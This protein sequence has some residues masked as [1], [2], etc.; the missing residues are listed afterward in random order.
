MDVVFQQ[1]HAFPILAPVC[2]GEDYPA[3]GYSSTQLLLQDESHP[4]PFPSLNGGLGGLHRSDFGQPNATFSTADSVSLHAPT[5]L[6]GRCSG[7]LWCQ[8][9]D[10]DVPKS[11]PPSSPSS[12]SFSCHNYNPSA[13]D[14]HGEPPNQVRRSDGIVTNTFPT[15]SELLSELNSTAANDAATPKSDYSGN[16]VQQ[17]FQRHPPRLPTNH[18]FTLPVQDPISSHEKK[19]QLLECLEQYVLYLHE[20]LSLLGAQPASLERVSTY[21]GLSSRSVRTLLVH[22]ENTNKKLNLKIM[23][24]EERFLR[25]LGLRDTYLRQDL[26]ALA[27]P[28]NGSSKPLDQ[29]HGMYL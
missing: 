5:P 6:S 8:I 13:L 20:Q 16:G 26:S 27:A 15:P 18:S 22:M 21:R 19:R 9:L 24:E 29:G 10:H 4:H 12:A 23:A 11:E 3:A 1:R 17:T 7:L 2:G 14:A 28:A 25:L